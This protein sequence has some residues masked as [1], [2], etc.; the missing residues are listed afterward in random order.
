M[1]DVTF[2]V[3]S[4]YGLKRDN[5]ILDPVSDYRCFART[6]I[7]TQSIAEGLDV[8]V[9]TGLAPKRLVWGLYGAGK[10][11]TLM[12]TTEELGRLTPIHQVRVECPDLTRKSRFHDLYREG[13][14]R[15]MGQDFVLSV[16]DAVIERVGLKKRDELRTVLK[17][18]F[19]DEELARAAERLY[20]PNFDR[21]KLW[22][23]ISGVGMSRLDLDGLGQTQD[24]TQAEAARLAEIIIQIG[25]MH[26]LTTGKTLVLILDEMER[27]DGI[28]PETL[29]TFMSGFT[30]L[31]DPNQTSVCVLIGSSA[32]VE[33]QMVDIFS[34][35]SPV[36]SRLGP[37]AR[38]EIP[39]LHDR[40]VEAFISGVVKYVRD[41]S[42]NLVQLMAQA[43]DSTK[44]SLT[45]DLFPFTRQ[46]VEALKSSTAS[47]TPREIT[48]QMTRALGRS[49]R[50][51]SLVI[52]SDCVA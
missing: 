3:G 1:R 46:A 22:R 43:K 5:F 50:K 19:G 21:L 6:D 27:L 32:A 8:D 33:A 29:T 40:D 45:S 4:R 34:A 13:I 23:W 26:R 31:V 39:A 47:L 11:H 44:E 30:R 18:E 42:L 49:H 24:L 9:V 35:G 37:E 14:M 15:A 38:I 48:I 12:R 41:E 2:T 17:H 10:T 20:D 16:F 28:G 52:S 7:P 51:Q 25:R 36:I